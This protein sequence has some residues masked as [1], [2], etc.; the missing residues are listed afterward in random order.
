M[1]WL[2][3]F[4]NGAADWLPLLFALLLILRVYVLWRTLQVMPRVTA[5]KTVTATSK[6][7]WAD[8]AGLEEA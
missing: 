7:S 3:T 5:A 1:G 8:V 2:I 6:V 4:R